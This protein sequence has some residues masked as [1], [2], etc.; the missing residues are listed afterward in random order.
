[1]NSEGKYTDKFGRLLDVGSTV[2]VEKPEGDVYG[3]GV[4]TSLPPEG[5]DWHGFPYV[6]LHHSGKRHHITESNLRLLF[7]DTV[8]GHLENAIDK[9]KAYNAALQRL[10]DGARGGNVRVEMPPGTFARRTIRDVEVGDQ[11]LV[12]RDPDHGLV[13]VKW[14]GPST[15]FLHSS[16]QH[17]PVEVSDPF[18]ATVTAR[19]GW[20]TATVGG[21]RDEEELTT[22]LDTVEGPIV[23]L[24]GTVVAV[25]IVEVRSGQ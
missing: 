23:V 8:V 24:D 16:D 20:G 10:L 25:P 4:I 7:E 22:C 17:Y 2:Q 15:L 1:M 13:P 11:V 6:R 19:R 21:D 3:T 9:A 14:S 12:E 5:N 18:L